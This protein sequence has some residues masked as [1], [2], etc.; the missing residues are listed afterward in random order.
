MTVSLG[1]LLIDAAEPAVVTRFWEATLGEEAAHQLLRFRQ[2]L[3]P[4]PVKNRVH[5]DVYVRDIAPLLDL[6]ATV[7]AEYLPMRATLADIEGNEFCAFLDPEMPARPLGRVFAVCTDSDRPT[8]IAAWWA[9]VVGADVR[10]GPDGTP[11]Y[12]YTPAGWERLV[13]KFVPVDDE[14]LVP[15]RWQWTLHADTS[16]LV[17]VG[18]A[19]ATDGTLVDP[20]GNEFSVRPQARPAG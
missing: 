7:L 5:F 20:Q 2:E 16:A 15:N 19:L 6:G 1:P 3:R 17:A 12:L 8:E 9:G 18:A 4:K 13:W 14:R 10:D 11:R